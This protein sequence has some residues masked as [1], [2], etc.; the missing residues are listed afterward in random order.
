MTDFVRAEIDAQPSWLEEQAETLTEDVEGTRDWL[1][2]VQ[3]TPLAKYSDQQLLS[4]LDEFVER[5]VKLGPRYVLVLWYPIRMEHDT[6]R[7]RYADA[8]AAAIAARIAT[9]SI[10][11]AAD[12]FARRLAAEV[13]RR[14]NADTELARATPLET[15]RAALCGTPDLHE[16]RLRAYARQFLVTRDGVR[17]EDAETYCARTGIPFHGQHDVALPADTLTGVSAYPGKARG[18]AALIGGPQDFS[19]FSEG[20]VLVTA[21]TTPDYEMIMGRAAGIVTD[22]GGATSHAAILARETA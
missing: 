3:R 15:L 2:T 8:I 1:S 16:D 21:M 14:H 9:H 11:G 4:I 7:D 18:A 19:G 20:D 6:N 10:G 12:A 13:L 17:H 5:N 22:E